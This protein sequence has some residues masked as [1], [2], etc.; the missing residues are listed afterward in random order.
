MMM[1]TLAHN[2]Q[3]RYRD[4]IPGKRPDCAAKDDIKAGNE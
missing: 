4:D 1:G 3:R 2:R